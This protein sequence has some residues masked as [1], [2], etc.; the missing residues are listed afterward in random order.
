MREWSEAQD[1]KVQELRARY[2]ESLA[3]QAVPRGG[4]HIR[5]P[6]QMSGREVEMC[7]VLK[8]ARDL[9]VPERIKMMKRVRNEKEGVRRQPSLIQA[10]PR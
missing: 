5:S 7:W 4:R 1:K 10:L 9:V 6:A 2:N 3:T 8:K